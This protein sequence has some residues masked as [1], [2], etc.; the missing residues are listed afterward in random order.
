VEKT[1]PDEAGFKQTIA[2]LCHILSAAIPLLITAM[3][4]YQLFKDLL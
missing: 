3:V 4:F 2:A 1:P